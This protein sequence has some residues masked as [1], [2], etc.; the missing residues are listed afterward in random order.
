[1]F[2][3]VTISKPVAINVIEDSSKTSYLEF[4]KG[5]V[6][7]AKQILV[8]GTEMH[9]DAEELLINAGSEQKDLWGI[10]LYPEFFGTENF[11]EFDSLI[12]IRPKENRSRYV[13][14]EEIRKKII[15]L[16]GNLVTK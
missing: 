11:V 5:V 16:I 2:E 13:E 4:T 7:L 6:D 8:I 12:N 1:M 3:A 9:S 10:N 15:E 14:K